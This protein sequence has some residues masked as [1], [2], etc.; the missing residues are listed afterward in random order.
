MMSCCR[1]ALARSLL[2]E[3]LVY[4][5]I[6]LLS[7]HSNRLLRAVKS[8]VRSSGMLIRYGESGPRPFCRR[9]I[10]RESHSHAWIHPILIRWTVPDS[11][12]RRLGASCSSCDINP[13]HVH[14]TP[15]LTLRYPCRTLA[16]LN[17]VR[18]AIKNIDTERR[19]AGWR[20][21]R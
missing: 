8:S 13:L 16:T 11:T 5:M 12:C 2:S 21:S 19:S 9:C 10:A 20:T 6:P 15:A 7:T 1:E 4:Q 17:D 18:R 3:Q 14:H